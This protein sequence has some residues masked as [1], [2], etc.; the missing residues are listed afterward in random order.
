[1]IK[2]E[3][4]STKCD[5]INCRNEQHPP[6]PSLVTMT[7]FVIWAL[8][9]LVFLSSAEAAVRQYRLELTNDLVSPDG[10]VRR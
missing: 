9:L 4:L 2:L 8:S 6:Q 1:M 3:A 7:D 10:F 5:C